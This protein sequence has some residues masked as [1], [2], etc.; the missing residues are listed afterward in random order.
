MAGKSIKQSAKEKLDGVHLGRR[1]RSSDASF[2]CQGIGD[3][4]LD[5]YQV[6]ETEES[7]HSSD[8]NERSLLPEPLFSGRR[9]GRN[10]RFYEPYIDVLD[11]Y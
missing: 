5:R 2:V 3:G 9:V 11:E 6:S 4:G 7:S 10:T 1:R 8:E